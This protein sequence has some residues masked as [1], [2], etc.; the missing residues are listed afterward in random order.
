MTQ[1]LWLVILGAAIV[2]GVVILVVVFRMVREL[3]LDWY[4]ERK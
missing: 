2:L 1:T 3:I 4:R